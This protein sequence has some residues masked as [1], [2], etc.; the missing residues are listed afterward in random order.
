MGHLEHMLNQLGIPNTDIQ[1]K[2]ANPLILLFILALMH[3][4][5]FLENFPQK[6]QKN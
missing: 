4:C 3:N 5:K 6:K 1:A 2:S